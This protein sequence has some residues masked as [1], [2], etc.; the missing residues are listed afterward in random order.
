MGVLRGILHCIS[1]ECFEMHYK[2]QS[3]ILS[4]LSIIW[5]LIVKWESLYLLIPCYLYCLVRMAGCNLSFFTDFFSAWCNENMEP[6]S[7]FWRNWAVLG[8]M[9]WFSLVLWLYS[10]FDIFFQKWGGQV[11]VSIFL[12]LCLTLD[13]HSTRKHGIRSSLV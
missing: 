5:E 2:G 13:N 10:S 11:S 1:V 12:S 3:I 4:S 7:V 6:S 9:R 8:I